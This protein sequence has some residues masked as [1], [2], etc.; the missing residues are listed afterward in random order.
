MNITLYK[1]KVVEGED[2][3]RKKSFYFNIREHLYIL[4]TLPPSDLDSHPRS[5]SSTTYFLT[6]LIIFLTHCS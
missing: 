6:R 3:V 1:E 5:R 4:N 2:I